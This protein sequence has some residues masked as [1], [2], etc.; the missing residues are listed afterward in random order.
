MTRR[1]GTIVTRIFWLHLATVIAAAV[2][3]A[4][5]IYL[6]LNATLATFEHHSL[7]DHAT[8]IAA[9][10]KPADRGLRLELPP[11]LKALYAEHYGGYAFAVVDRTG[12]PLFSSLHDGGALFPTDPR[13]SAPTFFQRAQGADAF[14][15]AS[16]PSRSGGRAI[17]VQVRQDLG[18]PDVFVDDVVAQF[19]RRVGWL[20]APIV[21]LLLAADTFIVQRALAPA[22]EASRR[23][24]AIDPSRIDVRLPVKGLPSEIMPLVVAMN[25]ALDR[26]EAGFRIQREFTADAAHELRTPLAILRLRADTLADRDAARALRDDI[27]AMSRLVDQLLVIAELETFALSPNDCVDLRAIGLEVTSVMAPLAIAA[28]KHLELAV[29]DAPIWVRGRAEVLLRAVRNLVENAIAH[30]P[31][32]GSVTVAAAADG[33]LS[34]SDEG[35][36]IPECE[37]ELVFQR[38][39]RRERQTT[40]GG[41][42][43][44]SIVR[45]IVQVHGGSIEIASTPKSGTRF[46]MRLRPV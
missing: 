33:V 19:L 14:Y 41:G 1:L 39:W 21:L 10:V 20:I 40:R 6:L 27:D 26:L 36:G 31:I 13:K 29:D 23:A 46:V 7:G 4:G 37:R 12:R 9:A 38:F 28:G 30:T 11:D 43:G 45:Q 8:A 32:G 18:D 5:A 22:L 2:I 24:E 44:L 42:L 35:P 17:W 16:Y 34:V 3:M 25:R 15:G